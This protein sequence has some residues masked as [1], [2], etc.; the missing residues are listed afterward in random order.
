MPPEGGD[1]ILPDEPIWF[2][3]TPHHHVGRLV[4]I[5][6]AAAVAPTSV[7]IHQVL[8][9]TDFSHQSELVIEYGLQYARLFGAQ[10]EIAYVLPVQEYVVADVG[11]LQSGRDSARRDLHELQTKLR[12]TSNYNDDTQVRVTLLEGPVA[13]KLLERARCDHADLVVVGTHGRGSFGK[14]FLGSVAENVFRHSSVPVLTIGPNL[15][16][17]H[18]PV[19]FRH[20]LAPCDLS[21]KSHPAV[22]FAVQVA[23]AHES[24]LTVLHVIE[25]TAEGTKLDPERAKAGI[26]EN[27]A[28]IVGRGRQRVDIRYRVASGRVA[29]AILGAAAELDADLIVLGVR[30][31]SGVLDRFLWPIA[32]EVVREANCPVLTMRGCRAA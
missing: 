2:A 16:P 15:K 9:A 5:M 8:I 30:P 19:E 29:S 10:A 17:G 4:A 7:G 3:E 22:Q 11:G 32:Y 24:W 27:L 26:R 25:R 13:D 20:I 18:K 23:V 6:S 21:A 28:E 1:W 31:S 12:R 14:V